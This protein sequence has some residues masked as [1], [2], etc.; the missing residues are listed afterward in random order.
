MGKNSQIEHFVV[1]GVVVLEEFDDVG[2]AVPVEC[3][4]RVRRITHCDD[5]VCYICK[6]PNDRITFLVSSQLFTC[7]IQVEPVHLVAPP[8]LRN[9][10]AQR[11]ADDL[12]TGG[13]S[14][15]EHLKNVFIKILKNK[16]ISRYRGQ[17]RGGQQ[18]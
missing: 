13:G 12:R 2:H 11:G 8:V 7:E 10:C 17:W 4:P 14:A 1:A 18:G 3:F 15:I 9:D 6:N 16:L 5:T